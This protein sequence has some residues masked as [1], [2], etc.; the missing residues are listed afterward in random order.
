M[1]KKIMKYIFPVWNYKP[2]KINPIAKIILISLPVLEL[3]ISARKSGTTSHSEMFL[4][5][6]R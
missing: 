4:N 2:Q 6:M 5:L 1:Q 3:L